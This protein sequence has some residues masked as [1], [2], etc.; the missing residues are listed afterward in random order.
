M[1]NPLIH[2]LFM[3]HGYERWALNHLPFIIG[4]SMDYIK[5]I[6]DS[7]IHGVVTDSSNTNMN[8]KNILICQ[9]VQIILQNNATHRAHSPEICRILTQWDPLGSLAP[10]S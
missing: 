8:R 2:R 4:R 3:V 5:V 10:I 6:I 9:V 7:L 1:H